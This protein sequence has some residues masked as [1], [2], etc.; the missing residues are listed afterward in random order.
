MKRILVLLV[1]LVAVMAFASFAVAAKSVVAIVK[2]SP[3]EAKAMDGGFHI[4]DDTAHEQTSK[5]HNETGEYVRAL[6][7][8][9]S[10]EVWYQQ[11]K[12][13]IDMVGGIPL[14]KGETVLIKPNHVLS[15]YPMNWM[16]FGD[17]NSIQGAFSDPRA[18]L[19]AARI[20]A[21]M[22]AGRI[23]IAECPA[24]GDAWATFMNY[25]YTWPATVK[26]YADMGVKY[27]LIDLC[28]DWE[29]MKGLGLASPEYP[30]PKLLKQVQCLVN[31]SCFKTHEYAGVTFALKNLGIGLPSQ[32]VI[33]ACK[34]GLPH[35]NVAEVHVDVNYIAQKLVPRQ[36][37]ICDALYAG[38]WVPVAPYFLSGLLFA[39]KD[40][41]ALD[42][43]ATAVMNM[44]P[45]NIGTTRLAAQYKLGQMEYD[46]IE[47]VGTPLEEAIIQDFPRHPY[48]GRKWP[49]TP[50]MYGKVTNWDQL[51]RDP[52]FGV[53]NYPRW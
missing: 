30:M 48:K 16:G 35:R 46:Q 5:Y 42:A 3:E 12:K 24:L 21:E 51:Y 50:T 19:A 28:E 53:P 45:R 22:G 47:V 38:T 31:I 15:Y 25:G 2:A 11:M 52:I 23:I 44:N 8:P 26:K 20:C 49:W 37:H 1:A 7:S 33:G 14:K 39:S 9:E 13:A 29:M 34:F 17:D 27:E 6:W 41:V 10:E 32:R 40:P 18:S 36:I 43:I 4:N